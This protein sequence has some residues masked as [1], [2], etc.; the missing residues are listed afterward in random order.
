L[1]TGRIG[2][3]EAFGGDEFGYS[4]RYSLSGQPSGLSVDVE[5][6]MLTLSSPVAVG[7]YMFNVTV[8][9][10]KMTSKVNSFPV[11][12]NI[13][14][15][16]I[17]KKYIVDSGTYGNPVGNNYTTVL[18]NIRSAIIADQKAAGDEQL[19]ATIIFHAGKL[20]TY[21]ENRW[22]YGMQYLTIQTDS[23]GVRAQLQNVSTGDGSDDSRA[24][25][26]L[27]RGYLSCNTVS[28]PSICGLD[29]N[30]SPM[31]GYTI[32][33][34]TAGTNTVTLKSAADASKL[35]VGR[36]VLIA[37]FDQQGAGWPSNFRYHE[38]ARISSISGATVT[39]DRNLRFSH[40]DNYWENGPFSYGVARIYAIDRDDERTN[41][42]A[43]VK[44][45]EILS[46][47][48]VTK[49]MSGDFAYSY[50]LDASWENCIIPQWVPSM[51]RFVRVAG[52][53]FGSGTA[54]D[55]DKIM[56]MGIIDNC[57]VPGGIYEGTSLDYLLI[58]NSSIDN[59][60]YGI[61][62]RQIRLIN[63][64]MTGGS[65]Y[66]IVTILCWGTQSIDI[67]GS[68]LS[69]NQAPIGEWSLT[70]IKIGTNGTWSGN[71]LAVQVST[72]YTKPEFCWMAAAWV[73][74]IVYNGTGRT[75][76]WGYI[77]KITGDATNMYSDITWV[78]GSKPASGQTLYLP[79]VH[80][81]TVDAASTL[82]GSSWGSAFDDEGQ[83]VF[84]TGI[85]Q[86]PAGYPVALYGFAVNPAPAQL[87]LV[88]GNTSV[89]QG[90]NET[91]SV[92][93]V[94]DASSYTWTLPSGWT[95]TSTTN[96]ITTTVGNPGG[97]IS[98]KANSS[99]G[100]SNNQTLNITVNPAPA[101]PGSISGNT[102]SL[103]SQQ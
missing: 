24:P 81:I 75:S 2:Y 32:N 51:S 66:G 55:F 62:P 23:P 7:I 76:S 82:T 78:A 96:S 42:R 31:P 97:T 84:P 83:H 63:A 72:D 54:I 98:V 12:L 48:T 3:L 92:A 101:Q 99:C 38:Y 18:L 37:S 28:G 59:H 88:T 61:S 71:T 49:G 15:S 41:L 34:N 5:S 90:S 70:P 65:G 67:I 64:N 102:S 29:R 47:P 43:T 27:G 6:G 4:Y 68:R 73:G 14:S 10:R 50:T 19:R 89:C 9:N 53:T 69:C 100:S 40:Q 44:D 85:R 8:T 95:G 57:S 46:N 58:R 13:S 93:S 36:Y 16:I 60:T 22:D 45:I 33:T 25:F 91:Y 74:A 80:D 30:S 77:T 17:L 39:L 35:T 103:P 52:C 86:F 20:Y 26:I 21:T 1:E 79:H 94:S 56:S 11:T 87:G